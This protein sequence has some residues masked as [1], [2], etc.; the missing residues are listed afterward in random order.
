MRNTI[1]NIALVTAS[2]LLAAL[3]F[4][5]G[6]GTKG[7]KVKIQSVAAGN[8]VTDNDSLYVTAE[9]QIP[10]LF[11]RVTAGEDETACTWEE[12]QAHDLAWYREKGLKPYECEGIL[13]KGDEEGPLAGSFGYGETAPNVTVCLRGFGAS[14]KAQKSYLISIL[15]GKGRYEGQK[16]LVLNKYQSDPTRFMTRLEYGLMRKIPEMF[17]ARTSF[18]HLYVRDSTAEEDD[19]C[20]HDYGLFT[21]VERIN[22]DYLKNR[23]LDKDGALYEVKNFD[24]ERHEDVIVPASAPSYDREAM[25]EVLEPKGTKDHAPLIELLD[26]VNDRELPIGYIL[27]RYFDR[28]NLYSFMA[29][30]MLTDNQEAADSGYCIYRPR[31]LENWWF[32]SGDS[33]HAFRSVW[34]RMQDPRYTASWRNGIYI[35]ADSVLFERILKDPKCREELRDKVDEIATERLTKAAVDEEAKKLRS[36]SSGVLY[37]LPDRLN[38]RFTPDDYE[39]LT[40]SLGGAVGIC[41]QEFLDSLKAPWP[42]EADLP[43]LED[44]KLVFSWQEAWLPEGEKAVYSVRFSD[45]WDYRNA[46]FSADHLEE[47]EVFVDAPEP[48]QYFAEITAYAADGSSQ[49]SRS[50]YYNEDGYPVYGTM[51]FYIREDGTIYVS[52]FEEDDLD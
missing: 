21:L 24:W 20:Y 52:D 40:K 26:A 36:Q 43:V 18:V 37:E 33:H 46:I 12:L 50:L 48:G 3:G 4:C 30:H 23:N 5:L 6:S 25:E 28:D 31:M 8:A 17:S 7:D 47:T 41:Y 29:F 42:F 15:N 38:M 35:F 44:G 32:L 2:V 1:P 9:D 49:R 11:L 22:G 27:D 13:Q 51:C 10:A 16:E 34:K 14:R 19:G 45:S 39:T